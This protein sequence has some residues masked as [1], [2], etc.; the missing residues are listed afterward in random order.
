MDSDFIY[1]IHKFVTT[2]SYGTDN[3]SVCKCPE[4]DK[5]KSPEPDR[6]THVQFRTHSRSF[7]KNASEF[8]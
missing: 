3:F 2:F 4:T 5:L 7:Q 8:E 6:T 1:Q